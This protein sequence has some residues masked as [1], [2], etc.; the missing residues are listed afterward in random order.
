MA[1]GGFEGIMAQAQ[2]L[3]AKIAE[4]QARLRETFVEGQ[5]GGGLVKVKMNGRHDVTRVMIEPGA[6]STGDVELLEDLIVAAVAD[7]RVKADEMVQE[8]MA[9]AAQEVG[10][11]PAIA[12]QMMGGG[13]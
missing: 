3:Q 5:A 2:R 7:A 11:P 6:A 12:E 4:V 9:R 8:E 10:I 13:F 1:A